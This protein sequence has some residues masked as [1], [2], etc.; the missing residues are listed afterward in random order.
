MQTAPPL[1]IVGGVDD[2]PDPLDWRID[3]TLR[4][5]AGPLQTVRLGVH[6]GAT[7]A[8]DNRHDQPAP[9]RSPSGAEPTL[10]AN[11]P[12]RD[13]GPG[14]RF[15]QDLTSP[16]TNPYSWFITLEAAEPGPH[17]L[18]WDR[19][20]WP[21]DHDLQLYWVDHN[22]ILAMSMLEI[23][24]LELQLG[25]EPMVLEV[26]T[27][28]FVGV[29]DTP[30]AADRLRAAPNPFNPVTTLALDLARPGTTRVR[31][32][33]ARGQLVDSLDLGDLTAGRHQT[34]WQARD[35]AGREL[36]SGVYFA[37]IE[38]AGERVGEVVKLS[39]VR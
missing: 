25:A 19:I 24:Q 37:A 31:I 17:T 32:Y 22:L 26:R 27:P 38:R 28:N 33:N 1:P 4:S 2:L 12:S 30:A 8:F 6:P 23:D 35:R 34:T 10:Y 11:Q 13:V 9:P 7:P 5:D 36:P 21:V 18:S 16:N 20:D 3:L 29:E 14:T 39:L 15:R